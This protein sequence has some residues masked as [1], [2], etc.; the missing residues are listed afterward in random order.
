[1]RVVLAVKFHISDEGE[2]GDCVFP[3]YS[4]ENVIDLDRKGFKGTNKKTLGFLR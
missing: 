4:A 3:S 1:M 2:K